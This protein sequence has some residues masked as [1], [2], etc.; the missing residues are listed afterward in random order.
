MTMEYGKELYTAG[1]IFTFL[2]RMKTGKNNGR[3]V[4][5]MLASMQLIVPMVT[6]FAQMINIIQ[7]NEVS[8][9]TKSFVSLSIVC[10]I[11]DMFTPSLP[12]EVIENA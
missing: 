1:K 2:K 7:Q 5:I 3:I 8:F 12:K 4:N 10:K 9:I 6:V 11:D